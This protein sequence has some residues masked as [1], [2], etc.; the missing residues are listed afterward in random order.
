METASSP[1]VAY[2]NESNDAEVISII[3]N[4]NKAILKIKKQQITHMVEKSQESVIS[5]GKIHKLKLK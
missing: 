1:K 4:K 5:G 2:D 3:N